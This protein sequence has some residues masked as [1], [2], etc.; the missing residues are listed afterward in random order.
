MDDIDCSGE[1]VFV[2]EPISPTSEVA[3][4][5]GVSGSYLTLVTE[6]AVDGRQLLLSRRLLGASLILGCV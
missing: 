6:F 3:D 1:M 2:P 5:A 4:I